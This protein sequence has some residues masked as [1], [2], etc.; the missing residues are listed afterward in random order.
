[1]VYIAHGYYVYDVLTVDALAAMI[2][3][4]LGIPV[5]DF[6]TTYVLFVHVVGGA[7]MILG[8]FTRWAAWRICRSWSDRAVVPFPGRLL[9][10]RVIVDAA[11][12]SR[13]AAS[14]TAGLAGRNPR[15][16][17]SGYGTLGLTKD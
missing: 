6:A 4:R 10:A 9:P 3:K 7:M 16:V 2:N 14:S 8:V 17:L 13:V 1:M 15:S 12:A 11:G 5:G